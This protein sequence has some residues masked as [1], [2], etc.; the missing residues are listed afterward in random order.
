MLIY[1][2][3]NFAFSIYSLEVERRQ[4]WGNSR[5][6]GG[7]GVERGVEMRA[8]KVESMIVESGGGCVGGE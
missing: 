2:I 6:E 7:G 3:P 8:D 1:E 4:G 5:E